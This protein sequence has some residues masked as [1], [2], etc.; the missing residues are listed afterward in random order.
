MKIAALIPM[1]E[2]SQRVP[3]KNIKDFNGKPL[4]YWIFQTLMKVKS[5]DKIFLD[6]DSDIICEKV[7]KYFPD[8]IIIKRPEN[9]I[10][11]FVSVNKLINNDLKEID[12]YEYFIQ[13]HSTNPLLKSSTI[14]TAIDFYKD[15]LNIYDSVFSVTKIQSRFY[16]VYGNPINHD[17]I[18]LLRTQDI[19]PLYEENS[20]FYIFSKSSFNKT[21]AR[22]GSKPYLFEISQKESIDIDTNDDFL[23]AETF[24]KE[25]QL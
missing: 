17:P 19:P 1:K 5:I 10:G 18:E 25:K 11:D 16:D 14:T 6:T 15:N 3:N 22:I 13:T 9:L 12:N 21:K 7:R 20:C 4:F 8:I 24:S 2:H 23:L